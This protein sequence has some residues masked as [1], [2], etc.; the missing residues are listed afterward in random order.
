MPS[1][2]LR[3]ISL[4]VVAFLISAVLFWFVRVIGPWSSDFRGLYSAPHLAWHIV[5][6]VAMV[7][8]VIVGLFLIAKILVEIFK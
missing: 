7:L 3:R 6:L 1:Q 2:K 4:A 8:I 5:G